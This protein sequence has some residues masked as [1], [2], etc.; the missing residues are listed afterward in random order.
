MADALVADHVDQRSLA[1][2]QCTLER[3]ADVTRLLDV[4]AVTTDELEHPVVAD[5]V[6]HVERIGAALEQRHLLEA[7][8]PRAVVPEDRLDRQVVAHRGL[9]IEAADYRGRRRR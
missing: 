4:L 2:A 1:G 3:A 8:A 6:D 9:D 5:V 7:R